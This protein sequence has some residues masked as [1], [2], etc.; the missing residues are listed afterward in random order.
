MKAKTQFVRL[1]TVGTV[2]TA[3]G[4]A[5]K[6]MCVDSKRSPTADYSTEE[7]SIIDLPEKR[8]VKKIVP[9]SAKVVS[10]LNK[11]RVAGYE[12][13]LSIKRIFIDCF[14]LVKADST[15]DSQRKD[16][17]AVYNIV[18]KT[19][20]FSYLIQKRFHEFYDLYQLLKNNYDFK[21]DSFPSRINLFKSSEAVLKERK[22]QLETFLQVAHTQVA[23]AL[24]EYGMQVPE[25]FDFIELKSTENVE[26]IQVDK[27]YKLDQSSNKVECEDLAHLVLELSRTVELYRNKNSVSN[28]L[29]Q[30]ESIEPSVNNNE[31]ALFGKMTT[32]IR[33]SNFSLSSQDLRSFLLGSYGFPGL[34]N[35][36]PEERKV[37]H[38]KDKE[39]FT[40]LYSLIAPC[41]AV[42]GLLPTRIFQSVPTALLP[43]MHFMKYLTEERNSETKSLAFELL[44]LYLLAQP[45][46]GEEIFTSADA[47]DRFARWALITH[48][49]LRIP[50]ESAVVSSL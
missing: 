28:T 14:Q 44:T 37:D 23:R 13:V 31:S 22:P 46:A 21:F 9:K 12:K 48:P 33:K 16:Q 18:I 50:G 1:N 6:R 17:Y 3:A 2:S 24:K 19:L 32:V 39:Y 40:L 43:K 10:A 36:Y 26:I 25:Y 15:E 47:R 49:Q 35:L 27:N 30:S 7:E 5:D 41:R 42:L 4:S 29:L 8:E 20:G 38:R 45:A 34:L 11:P